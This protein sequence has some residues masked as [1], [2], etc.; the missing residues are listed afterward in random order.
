M[1]GTITSGLS[2]IGSLFVTIN[3]DNGNVV[4]NTAPFI[5]VS[6]LFISVGCAFD[7]GNDGF[8]QCFADSASAITEAF[9]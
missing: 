2:L 1:F 6:F 4:I 5:A 7:A 8:S 9:R 3:K